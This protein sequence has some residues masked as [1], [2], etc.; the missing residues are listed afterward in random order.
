MLDNSKD[1]SE[2]TPLEDAVEMNEILA[3]IREQ[4]SAATAKA[5]SN[6]EANV[7]V[8]VATAAAFSCTGETMIVTE[9]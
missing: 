1:V 4:L 2:R 3:V 8:D 7:G 6:L 9:Y 5:T